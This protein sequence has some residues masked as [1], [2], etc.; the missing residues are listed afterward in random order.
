MA[1]EP[2]GF[3]KKEKSDI[4][5]KKSSGGLKIWPE[6]HVFSRKFDFGR[7]MHENRLSVQKWFCAKVHVLNT[8]TLGCNCAHGQK[9][10]EK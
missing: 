3:L 8:F 7:S 1:L 10:G 5:M 4:L 9:Y 2:K 6:N